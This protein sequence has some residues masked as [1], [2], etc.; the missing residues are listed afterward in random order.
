MDFEVMGER[1]QEATGWPTLEDA[2]RR[3]EV[4]VREIKERKQGLHEA[5][6]GHQMAKT[7]CA[8]V[9]DLLRCMDGGAKMFR[10]GTK[11]T[12][13]S[14]LKRLAKVVDA[15][16]WMTV[17]L[18]V[19]LTERT[20]ERFYAEG[21]GL[22]APNWVDILE[23]N[24]GLN[25]TIRNVKSL[26]RP[27]TVKKKFGDLTL[28]DLR[29]FREVE[30]LRHS[31][32]GFEPWPTEVYEAM[33]AA[34]EVL[35]AE[36]PEMWLVNAMLRRLGLRD[37][38]LLKARREWIEVDADTGRAWLRIENRGSEFSV[39]KHG[40]GRRLELD[41]ELQGVLLP[42]EGFLIGGDGWSD[43]AR[44]ELIYKVHSQWLRRFIPDRAKSN[45]ELRMHAGSIVYTLYG[46]EAAAVFLGHKSVATTERYYARWLG[47]TPMLDQA[48]VA[49]ARV[50]RPA[51]S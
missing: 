7:R 19:L 8:T 6:R 21:Q 49:H 16:G 45:H 33:H 3:A 50:T 26:F 2:C 14:A 35:R 34:S 40:R 1:I 27:R 5:G 37:E 30:Y 9:G 17:G 4:R 38:E 15:E 41:A 12:Y 23:G 32:E 31:D 11:R 13:K 47:S 42:R 25:G 46:L 39:L 36:R 22:E 43:C 44:Y 48:M 18:D 28:P 29:E 51:G 10:D 20:V 24:G